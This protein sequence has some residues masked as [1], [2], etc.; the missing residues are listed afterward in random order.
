VYPL[1]GHIHRFYHHAFAFPFG[2]FVDQAQPDL[3]DIIGYENMLMVAF[4]TMS[5]VLSDSLSSKV[6]WVI[7]TE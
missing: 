7:S 6:W 2:G 4:P 5:L 1:F 3:K